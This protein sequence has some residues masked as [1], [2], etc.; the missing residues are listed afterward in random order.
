[1]ANRTVGWSPNPNKANVLSEHRNFQASGTAVSAEGRNALAKV[2]TGRRNAHMLELFLSLGALASKSRAAG[3]GRRLREVPTSTASCTAALLQRYSYPRP[4]QAAHFMP[5]QLRLNGLPIWEYQANTVGRLYLM[6]MFADVERLPVNFNRADSEAES[7]PLGL[8]ELAARCTGHIVRHSG[9]SG[10]R[11]DRQFVWNVYQGLWLPGLDDAIETAIANK[12]TKP[13]PAQVRH[14]APTFNPGEP[15]SFD[16]HRI[17][18][19]ESG[20]ASD[21]EWNIAETLAILRAYETH[22]TAGPRSTDVAAVAE[23]AE[24][25]VR[26]DASAALEATIAS[27][28]AS[29]FLD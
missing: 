10:G 29:S 19:P 25:G 12:Q 6:D 13:Q 14:Q 1:M 24:A 17:Q 16:P 7:G 28:P 9:S 22:T 21:T 3:S 5:G 27:A 18:L 26:G 15:W 11:V 23:R 2:H 20:G 8:K 4:D